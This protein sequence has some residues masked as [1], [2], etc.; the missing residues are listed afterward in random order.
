MPLDID[1][2]KMHDLAAAMKTAQTDIESQVAGLQRQVDDLVAEGFI[3][4]TSSPEFASVYKELNDGITK[5]VGGMHG[6]ATFLTKAADNFQETDH[7]L[8]KSL[9][10]NG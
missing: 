2:G 5:T 3:T 7:K 10:D 8:G 1:Y 9:K 4:D 6:L